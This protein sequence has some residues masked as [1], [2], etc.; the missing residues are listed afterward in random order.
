MPRQGRYQVWFA[1]LV[2]VAV[3]VAA[4]LYFGGVTPG[5]LSL[6]VGLLAIAGLVLA[7]GKPGQ[8]IAR[9]PRPLQAAL[10]AFAASLGLAALFSHYYRASAEALLYWLGLVFSFLLAAACFGDYE[11]WKRLAAGLVTLAAALAFW[12]LVNW[13]LDVQQVWGIALQDSRRVVHGTFVNRNHFAGYLSL[14]LPFC[15]ALWRHT[16]RLALKIL[17]TL[18]SLT[19]VAA[20]VFSL[21]R[22][23]WLGLAGS[24]VV[25]AVMLWGR[26]LPG[27]RS[28]WL[29]A[30]LVLLMGVM[31]LR[32]GLEPILLRVERTMTEDQLDSLGGRKAIWQSVVGMFWSSP[33][34]GLGP[35]TFGWFFPSYR[36]PGSNGMAWFAHN[37][38]LHLL[39]EGGLCLLTAFLGWLAVSAVMLRRGGDTSRR[40]LKRSLF[41]ASLASLAAF[42]IEIC[43]DFQAH[44]MACGYT[45]AVLLGAAAANLKEADVRPLTR[46]SFLPGLL[47]LPLALHLGL[48]T[49]LLES[50]RSDFDQGRSEPG[51]ARL[52]L[53]RR[54][55]PANAELA[56]EQAEHL[57]EVTRFGLDKYRAYGPAWRAYVDAIRNQ[58]EY[59]LYWLRAGMLLETAWQ[60]SRSPL[61]RRQMAEVLADIARVER[62]AGLPETD[63]PGKIDFYYGRALALDPYNP[64]FLDI[65]AIYQIRQGRADLAFPLVEEAIYALPETGY[66]V[67]FKPYLKDAGFRRVSRNGLLR[68]M[69]RNPSQ[70]ASIRL[71]LAAWALEDGDLAEAEKL[72][73]RTGSALPDDPQW[74]SLAAQLHFRQDAP[75]RAAELLRRYL[76]RVDWRRDGLVLAYS[77]FAAQGRCTEALQFFQRLPAP[78]EARPQVILLTGEIYEHLGEPR[79]AIR[80][81]EEYRRRFPNE[82]EVLQR[83]I[84]LYQSTGN[85]VYAEEALRKLIRGGSR[86]PEL[87]LSLGQVM[88]SQGELDTATREMEVAAG[89]FPGHPGILGQLA[90][91]YERQSRFRDA[92]AVWVRLAAAKPEDRSA[93]LNAARAYYLAGETDQAVRIYRQLLARYPADAGIRREFESLKVY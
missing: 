4:P 60:V 13:L 15:I 29:F 36:L 47:L 55:D 8:P 44:I 73:R 53:A 27:K 62:A 63:F 17:L 2:L 11:R 66:H 25:A 50:G 42:Q 1:R 86:D 71:T 83:L 90:G 3:L 40:P 28:W 21:S 93:G 88:I 14:A 43:F 10:F 76:A 20:I 37:D 64:Y 52:E 77:V 45:L 12:G 19:I 5:F 91:L 9:V 69:R 24:A 78:P 54:A 41:I 7:T 79:Q 85:A 58:P 39:A 31:I 65:M 84:R 67:H 92:A 23:S 46:W 72:L 82:P 68:A 87:L 56:H 49:T 70:A 26:R 32:I 16:S 48:S 80:Q 81:Y 89:Q 38:Y 51:F 18:A 30:I 33:L 35:G 57:V 74:I 22:G 61:G 34:T 75:V 6:A 59:G